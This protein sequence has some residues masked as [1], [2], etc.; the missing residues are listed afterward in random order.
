MEGTGSDRIA[1]TILGVSLTAMLVVGVPA[2]I[3][4]FLYFSRQRN[5]NPV[6][7][8]QIF[9]VWCEISSFS[10]L[11]IV[12]VKSQVLLVISLIRNPGL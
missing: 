7:V 1:D 9:T 4:A 12:F 5:N 8:S 10:A 2:N 3:T 6:Q 11:F